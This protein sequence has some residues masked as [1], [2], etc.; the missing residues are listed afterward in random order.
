MDQHVHIYIRLY[1]L[2]SVTS[3][4]MI[5]CHQTAHAVKI[6]LIYI[7]NVILLRKMLKLTDINGYASKEEQKGSVEQCVNLLS[8]KVKSFGLHVYI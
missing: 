7:F 5:V 3:R 4:A 6:I 8:S 2:S 1:R